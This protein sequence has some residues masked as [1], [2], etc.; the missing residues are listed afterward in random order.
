MFLS[1]ADPFADYF[2]RKNSGLTIECQT[3]SVQIR[4][5]FFVRPDLGPNCVYVRNGYRQTT[6][7]GKDLKALSPS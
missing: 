7:V 2:V 6:L 1:S 3:V 4:S 5:D